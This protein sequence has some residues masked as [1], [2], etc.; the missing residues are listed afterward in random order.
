MFY[1]AVSICSSTCSSSTVIATAD[2]AA[3]LRV[4]L[5]KVDSAALADMSAQ[6]MPS[7]I[8]FCSAG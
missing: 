7:S 6:L 2:A 1:T 5:V 8:V 3:S 4:T